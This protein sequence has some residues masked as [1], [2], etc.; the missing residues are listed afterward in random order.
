VAGACLLGDR[1]ASTIAATMRRILPGVRND[2]VDR[3]SEDS[4]PASD[5]TPYS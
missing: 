4:F 5:P 2:V 1:F 3:A